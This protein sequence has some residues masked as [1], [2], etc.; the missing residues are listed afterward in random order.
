LRVTASGGVSSLED[1]RRLKD[2]NNC[3]VDSVIIGK[4]LYEGRFTIQEALRV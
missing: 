1:I 2:V 3:G 4:A